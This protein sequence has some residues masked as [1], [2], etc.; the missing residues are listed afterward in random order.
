MVCCVEQQC[1]VYINLPEALNNLKL[2]NITLLGLHFIGLF[3]LVVLKRYYKCPN[4]FVLI[5]WII[6]QYI[7]L[8]IGI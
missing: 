6:L 1:V 3:C 5:Y 8:N 7:V 4:I 2:Y